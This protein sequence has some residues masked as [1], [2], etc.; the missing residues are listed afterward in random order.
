MCS[1]GGNDSITKRDANGHQ[2]S[3]DQCTA[4]QTRVTLTGLCQS[5]NAALAN[6]NLPH[7]TLDYQSYIGGPLHLYQFTY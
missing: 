5:V 2:Q 1:T 6:Y 3:I 4:V 7:A